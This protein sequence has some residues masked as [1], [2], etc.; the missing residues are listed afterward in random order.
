L[1]VF[2]ARRLAG[3]GASGRPQLGDL[4]ADDA[5]DVV[6]RPCQWRPGAGADAGCLD[7]AGDQITFGEMSGIS[8]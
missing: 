8:T 5:V 3:L 7:P 6:F 2:A 1:L 4:A